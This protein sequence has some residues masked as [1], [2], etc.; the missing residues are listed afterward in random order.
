MAPLRPTRK[1]KVLEALVLELER[2]HTSRNPFTWFIFPYAHLGIF[3]GC[4]SLVQ[5]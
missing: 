3:G 4:L 1:P 2:D 5:Q